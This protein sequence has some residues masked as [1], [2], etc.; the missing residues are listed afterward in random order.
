MNK[1]VESIDTVYITDFNLIK[2]L[3]EYKTIFSY[4]FLRNSK[5]YV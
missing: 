1:I 4:A 3:Y 2:N 5:M